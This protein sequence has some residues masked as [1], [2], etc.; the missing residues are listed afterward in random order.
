MKAKPRRK[1]ARSSRRVPSPS[2]SSARRKRSTAVQKALAIGVQHHEAGRLQEAEAIY[3]EM[4]EIQ[5]DNPALLYLLGRV[6]FQQG[7]SSTAVDYISKAISMNGSNASFHNDLGTVLTTQGKLEEAIA[8][9]H[10]AIAIKPDYANAHYNL[11]NALSA[12]GKPD[13]AITSYRQTIAIKPDYADA[14]YNLGNVLADHDNPDEA[15]ASYQQAIAIS[16][17]YAK[18][19][20]NLGNVLTAK[21]NLDE[22]IASYQRA[23]VLEPRNAD[24]HNNLG[25]A[26]Q[27]QGNLDEAISSYRQALAIKPDYVDAHYNLGNA[28]LDQDKFDAA[29]ECFKEALHLKPDYAKAHINLGNTFKNQGKI[30]AAIEYYNRALSLKPEYA[31]A[32]LNKAFALLLTGNFAE[33]WLE[34][35]WRLQ[36]DGVVQQAGKYTSKLTRWDGSSLAGKN[37]LVLSEQGIGDIIHF[38]RYLPLVQARGGRVIFQCQRELVPLL[39]SFSGIDVLV[40]KSDSP[41][42][43]IACEVY[44]PLLSLP[45]IFGTTVDTIVAE[46]PYL[47]ADPARIESWSLRVDSEDFKI[48]LAWA[49]NPKYKDDHSRS[50]PLIKFSPL[51]R[52]PGVTFYSLVKWPVGEQFSHAPEGLSL[53]DFSGTLKDFAESAALIS[54]LDLVI[55]VDTAVAHLAGAMAQRVWTILPF[56]PD[57]RWLL[58]REKS[59]WYPT[60]RLFRQPKPGDWDTV[61]QRVASELAKLINPSSLQLS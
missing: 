47:K 1:P 61:I 35:E 36:M 10:R 50:C 43:D 30:D 59:P 54:N 58:G 48:G 5:P 11:G 18:A 9:Y 33:G 56:D 39:D 37:I 23:I 55:S 34:Y 57:W 2:P 21:G 31:Q 26:L 24:A 40:G 52:I 19:H 4:L 45:M 13:A 42:P 6:A 38:I 32:H 49:G 27:E 60:M 25:Y 22:A 53:V 15:I 14:Y 51:A 44:I 20:I 3:Q 29:I 46:V 8:S 17:D 12:Q 7:N 28:F 16:P 41:C